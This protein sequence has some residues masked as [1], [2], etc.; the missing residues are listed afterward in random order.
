MQ[1]LGKIFS[2]KAPTTIHQELD[3]ASL[4]NKYG[5]NQNQFQEEQQAQ[6]SKTSK[7]LRMLMLKKPAKKKEFGWDREKRF[8][9]QLT[10]AESLVKL[11]EERLLF[12]PNQWK[13]NDVRWKREL[14]DLLQLSEEFAK[15]KIYKI[16]LDILEKRKRETPK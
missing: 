13:E 15:V 4:L 1:D 6:H 8:M 9:D 16:S 5:I 3:Q 14:N 11:C 10:H 2:Q 12:E 7:L